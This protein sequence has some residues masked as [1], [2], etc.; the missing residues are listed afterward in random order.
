MD[1]NVLTWKAE[2]YS[3][4]AHLFHD[5]YKSECGSSVDMTISFSHDERF[6]DEDRQVYECLY[7]SHGSGYLERS[8][9]LQRE[10]LKDPFNLGLVITTGWELLAIQLQ[11]DSLF[12]TN[13]LILNL[14]LPL[15]AFRLKFLKFSLDN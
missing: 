10:K 13:W 5:A 11:K 12:W 1:E 8:T 4:M 2:K 6:R 14:N 7:D 3:W 9:M 15:N